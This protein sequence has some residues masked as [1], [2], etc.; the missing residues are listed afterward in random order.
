[1]NKSLPWISEIIT[2]IV[3]FVI[4]WY[5]EGWLNQFYLAVVLSML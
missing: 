1:M 3:L 4:F 2:Q 5:G